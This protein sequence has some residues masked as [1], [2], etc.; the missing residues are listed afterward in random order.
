MNKQP[1]SSHHFQRK[2]SEFCQVRI[3]PLVSGRELQNIR[4]YL[5]TLILHR[6]KPPMRGYGVDWR[7]FAEACGVE[8][9][10]TQQVRLTLRPALDAIIRWLKETRSTRTN[11]PV[12][13]A[14]ERQARSGSRSSKAKAVRSKLQVSAAAAKPQSAKAKRG[15]RPKPIE[16]FPKSLFESTREPEGFQEALTYHM[17]RH[18]ETYWHLH[19]AVV[20]T[21]ETFDP[22]TLLSWTNGTK[23]PRSIESFEILSRIERR[24]RLPHGYFKAR[25]PHQSRSATGLD[26]GSDVGPAERRRLVWHLP[27]NFN[28]LSFSKREEILEWVRR[29]I[30]TGSTDYRRF[31]AAA[32][33]QRYAIRFP[34]ISYGGSPSAGRSQGKLDWSGDENDEA[35]EDPDLLA[36]VVDAPPRLAMEMAG[37][38]RFKMAT[39]TTLGFQRNGVWGEETAS[40]KVEHLGLMF[41]ALA[42]SPKRP[43]KGYGVSL[44]QLTFGLLVFP[45]VWDWYLQWRERRRG[46]YT[47]W[48]DD[49]LSVILSLTRPATGWL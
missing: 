36:G 32:T 38:V 26:V 3:S 16:E 33:K 46:F 8:S 1:A 15:P 27:D 40:Q 41:G 34:G 31:Q 11:R 44:S 47:R 22:K 39:L 49:M 17:R 21:D 42:A 2:I 19:H 23:V 18:G 14:P 25:L 7:E 37:L 10:L 48:E 29:V 24:Y 13:E 9:E 45:G 12:I 20:R 43:I 35:I 6:K 30:I 28:E 4:S 5:T